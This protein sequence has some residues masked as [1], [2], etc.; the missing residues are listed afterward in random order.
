VYYARQQ[1]AGR[2]VALKLCVP[3]GDAS[4]RAVQLFLR[5]VSILSRLDHPGIVQFYEMGVAQG[6]FYFAMEYVDPVKLDE[7]V[8]RQS[9]QSQV[10]TCCAV[11]CQTLEALR[12][13]HKNSFVHRDIK[14]SNI[15]VTRDGKRLRTKLTDF[16]L[17]KNFENAG[18][19][20][21]TRQGEARGTPAYMAPEQVSNSRDVGPAADI[22]SVG[23]TLYHFLTNSGPYDFSTG[24]DWFLVVLEDDPI[25][26]ITRR[27]DVPREL[28]EIVHR[29]LARKPEDRFASA[30]HMYRALL[31][32]AKSDV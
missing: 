20:G 24:K 1:P 2:D 13:A 7:I 3:Q 14:P 9:L 12:Y 17:A 30:A 15:L 27:P 8:A 29:A 16:G 25:P 21:I 11:A 31:R 18:F 6:Q 4:E 22:Y 26:L 19:S 23:A 32:F 5:E 28:A 10:K